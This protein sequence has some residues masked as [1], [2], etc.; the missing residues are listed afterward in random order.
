MLLVFFYQARFVSDMQLKF[1]ENLF[2]Y[3]IRCITESI[4]IT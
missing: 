3:Y 1:E 2:L 4:C